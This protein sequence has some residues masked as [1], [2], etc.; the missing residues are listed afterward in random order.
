MRIYHYDENGLF[1]GEGIAQPSPLEPG[2]FLVPARATDLQP[3]AVGEGERARFDGSAWQIEQIPEREP[4][5][6]P[7]LTPEE[8]REA[9]NAPIMAQIL[10][11]EAKQ[12][13]AV[14]EALLGQDGAIE[15]LEGIEAEIVALRELLQ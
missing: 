9:N 8:Q 12:A 6:V 2:R 5:S 4:E 11:L 10:E 13:R 14:R 15:R 3:P 1:V 7:D